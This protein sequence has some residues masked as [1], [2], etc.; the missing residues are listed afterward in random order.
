MYLARGN[1]THNYAI[2]VVMAMG[3]G[4]LSPAPCSLWFVVLR[5]IKI[6]IA[7]FDLLI[8][9]LYILWFVLMY[10]S[11][12]LFS[13]TSILIYLIEGFDLLVFIFW[14]LVCFL[15]SSNWRV[16]VWVL[17]LAT[18]KCQ[19][20][21]I[22][23]SSSRAPP[24]C[25]CRKNFTRRMWASQCAPGFWPFQTAAA[26]IEGKY[27]FAT[28]PGHLDQGADVKMLNFGQALNKSCY[29]SV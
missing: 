15:R 7:Y 20:S 26:A 19:F 2:K 14:V 27:T 10:L 3:G 13:P 11:I 21:Q 4:A 6:M 28:R 17:S 24:I 23:R 9:K 5:N 1:W 22:N 12:F 18:Y 29:R 8:K 16:A 25:V